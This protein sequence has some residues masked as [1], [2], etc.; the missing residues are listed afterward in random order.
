MDVLEAG[1]LMEE[2]DCASS[3]YGAERQP[4]SALPYG[5]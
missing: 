2:D 1:L 4:I 3:T 5:N